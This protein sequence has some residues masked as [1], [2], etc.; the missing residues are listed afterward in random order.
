MRWYGSTKQVKMVAVAAA[1]CNEGRGRPRNTFSPSHI[2]AIAVD[3]TILSTTT[4]MQSPPWCVRRCCSND[5]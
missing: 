1:D 4:T 2:V 5:I 3:R